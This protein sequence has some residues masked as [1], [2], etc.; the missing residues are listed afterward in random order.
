MSDGFGQAALGEAEFAELVVGE[1]G[2]G[3]LGEG[4]LPDGFGG[5][6]DYGDVEGVEE[7]SSAEG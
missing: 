2:G 3:I 5:A 7:E 1:P 4:V 6:V